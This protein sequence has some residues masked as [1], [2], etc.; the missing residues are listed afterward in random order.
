MP[1]GGQQELQNII[2]STPNWQ[3]W[4]ETL[5]AGTKGSSSTSTTSLSQLAAAAVELDSM[6]EV[7]I[8]KAV[9]RRCCIICMAMG[10]PSPAWH[11][12][13]AT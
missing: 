1:G 7:S 9:V 10:A 6:P 12:F 11:H 8:D 5:K 13:S 3:W 2:S 4:R